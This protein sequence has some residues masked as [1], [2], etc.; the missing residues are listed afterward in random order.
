MTLDGN[1]VQIPE[2]QRVQEQPP[3][4]H[5]Q[6]QSARGLCR[7]HRLRRLDQRGA[8][9]RAGSVGDHPAVLNDPELSVLADSLEKSTVGQPADLFL[10]Q[11]PR[12]QLAES[13]LFGD[14]AGET[15]LPRERHLDA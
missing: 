13:A 15:R 2:R 9:D 8:G 12:T 11:R 7:R 6:R 1:L 4:L 3:Q 14:P 5:D 10:A